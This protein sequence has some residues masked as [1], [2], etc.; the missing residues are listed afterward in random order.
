M[1]NLISQ[2]YF[3]RTQYYSDKFKKMRFKIQECGKYQPSRI[4]IE[5]NLAVETTM[6]AAKIQA[7]TLGIN[8]ELK[9]MIKYC[10]NNNH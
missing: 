5:N 1:K 8:L 7:V 3:D 10:A 9:N 2:I 4:F 6:S